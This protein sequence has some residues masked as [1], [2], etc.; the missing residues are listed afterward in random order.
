MGR[1]IKI[2]YPSCDNIFSAAFPNKETVCILMKRYRCTKKGP[3]ESFTPGLHYHDFLC[4]KQPSCSQ[5][6][7]IYGLSI[8]AQQNKAGCEREQKFKLLEV[9]TNTPKDEKC[10]QCLAVFSLQYMLQEVHNT[11]GWERAEHGMDLSQETGQK[12]RSFL[13]L[14]AMSF[15]FG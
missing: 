8:K 9:V 12:A 7:H 15:C 13:V 6:L 4:A 11:R 10:G 1:D 3:S 5:L 2:I 14:T